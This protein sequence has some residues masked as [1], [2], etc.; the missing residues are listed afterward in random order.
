MLTTIQADVR[1][2]TKSIV[3]SGDPSAYREAVAERFLASPQAKSPVFDAAYHAVCPLYDR[4]P[5]ASRLCLIV[6]SL[7][8]PYV[9]ETSTET[10]S[11]TS[12]EL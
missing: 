7:D 12:T 10:T 6:T 11:Y 1:R 4:L 3:F 2:K 5:I 8:D 9:V